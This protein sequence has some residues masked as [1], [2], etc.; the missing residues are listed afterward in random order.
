MEETKG[1]T[2]RTG[3]PCM[4]HDG[5]NVAHVQMSNCSAVLVIVYRVVSRLFVN[6]YRT[7]SRLA[8]DEPKE[9]SRQR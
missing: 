6:V 5:L 8:A 3:G 4:R 9:R 1:Q 2:D 7:V